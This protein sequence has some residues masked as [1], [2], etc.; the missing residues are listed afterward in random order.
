MKNKINSIGQSIHFTILFVSFF[1][2]TGCGEG[3]DINSTGGIRLTVM[4]DPIDFLARNCNTPQDS[5]FKVS[6]DFVKLIKTNNVSEIIHSFINHF[7]TNFSTKQLAKYFSGNKIIKIKMNTDNVSLEKF[8]IEEFNITQNQVSKILESRIKA[9]NNGK[10][11]I[12]TKEN[13]ELVCEIQ[14]L[15]DISRLNK[16][17]NY[18][19]DL[20]FY[21]MYDK[22]V[23]KIFFDAINDSLGAEM[24]NKVSNA[25][26][27]TKV[28][29]DQSIL[30]PL[31][32]IINV[33]VLQKEG[34]FVLSEKSSIGKSKVED[35]I[36]VNKY[37]KST[38]ANKLFP[39][40][41][42][43]LWGFN[44]I[45]DENAKR[46]LELFVV[47][48][49]SLNKSVINRKHVID[50][51]DEFEDQTASF[52]IKIIMDTKGA[53]ELEK[54]TKK[55]LGKN[56][57]VVLDKHVLFAPKIHNAVTGEKITLNGRFTKE[58]AKDLA[59]V[60]KGGTMPIRIK[61]IDEL[62]IQPKK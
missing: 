42:K 8:L 17:I 54:F 12:E 32:K 44:E 15:N 40:D 27:T 35:T 2:L 28:N 31:Y 22:E 38:V 7:A 26:D 51:I 21:E 45:Y 13:G 50:A 10:A 24:I 61:I 39:P 29:D 18:G 4:C 6:L 62:I 55:N 19:G 25:N 20:M 57:C 11:K 23:V 47:K 34:K 5:S 48:T 60:I 1:N 53:D 36:Q 37:L 16:M 52:A 58:E 56:L 14:E 30:N 9:I 43:F 33:D 41:I 3:K 59:A 46:F 49:L